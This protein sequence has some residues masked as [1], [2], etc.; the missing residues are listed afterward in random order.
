MPEEGY[1]W[2]PKSDLLSFEET[3]RVVRVFVAMGIRSVRLTGGEPTIRRDIVQLV[4]QLSAIE[5]L[6]DIAMTTNASHLARLA[7]PLAEA[8]LH[9]INVSLDSLDETT[10]ATLTRGGRLS[11]VLEGI[12]AAREAGLGPIKINAV[13]LKGVNDDEVVSLTEAMSQEPEQT[14]LRFIE[15][16]PFE[17]RGYESVSAEQIREKL[18]AKYTLVPIEH[19]HVGR[20]PARRWKVVET[21]L[22]LGFIAPLS[23]RFCEG[24]N[25]LRLMADGHLRT[26]LAHEDTP[27]LLKLIRAGGS[28][29]VLQRAIRLMVM[30]KPEG[31]FCEL[32]GGTLFE[33]VMTRVGG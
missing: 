12:A 31:H 21:G 8:G 28:D 19:G 5:G 23:E 20:G 30:G 29:Q 26:C 32:D 18:R 7:R 6:E 1:D 13:V 22:E 24:C 33:G 17:A 25:R 2:M 4:E 27:S 11:D 16:M 10:F 14:V 15:Y 9:R 3:A